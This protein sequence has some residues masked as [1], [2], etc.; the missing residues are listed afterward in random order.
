MSSSSSSSRYTSRGVPA[1]IPP[2]YN[3]T[4]RENIGLGQGDA[5]EGNKPSANAHHLNEKAYEKVGDTRND[6]YDRRY[7]ELNALRENRSSLQAI[8][9]DLEHLPVGM[10][11]TKDLRG[12]SLGELV[13]EIVQRYGFA[14]LRGLYVY[15]VVRDV[16]LLGQR[17]EGNEVI[18]NSFI[19]DTRVTYLP[20]WKV[21]TILPIEY[22]EGKKVFFTGGTLKEHL[23]GMK[24]TFIEKGIAHAHDDR[25]ETE[26]VGSDASSFFFLKEVSLVRRV[27]PPKYIDQRINVIRTGGFSEILSS[28]S[29]FHFSIED[30]VKAYAVEIEKHYGNRLKTTNDRAVR[31]FKE[32]ISLRVFGKNEVSN[33]SVVDPA[34]G[35]SIVLPGAQQCCVDECVSELVWLSKSQ[36]RCFVLGSDGATRSIGLE[37]DLLVEDVRKSMKQENV[38]SRVEAMRRKRSRNGEMRNLRQYEE[39]FGKEFD[40]STKNGYSSSLF[41]SFRKKMRE[42]YRVNPRIYYEREE[43]VE[44]DKDGGMKVTQRRLME[45]ANGLRTPSFIDENPLSFWQG[46][47][48]NLSMFRINI[49]GIIHRHKPKSDQ[50]YQNPGNSKPSDNDKRGYHDFFENENDEGAKSGMLHAIGLFPYVPYSVL[51][52]KHVLNAFFACIEKHTTTAMEKAKL[53]TVWLKNFDKEK[54][55]DL[56]NSQNER[57]EKGYVK[58]LIYNDGGEEGRKKGKTQ[59]ENGGEEEEE[60]FQFEGENKPLVVAYDIET[61]ELTDTAI[62]K[63]LIPEKYLVENPT[64]GPYEQENKQA[65][66]L[67]QWVP[68]NLSDEGMI[69]AKKEK[70]GSEPRIEYPEESW[71]E[72]DEWVQGGDGSKRYKKGWIALDEV[73][74][75]KGGGNLGQCVEDFLE[76][77]YH[78][79]KSHKYTSAHCYAHNGSQ[80]DSI[81]IQAFNTKYKIS[82]V[83]KVRG[84]ILQM[85]ILVPDGVRQTVRD[86]IQQKSFTITFSDTRKFL[87][88]SLASLC[89][90]FKLP[91]CWSKLDF[92]IARINADN[93][94]LPEVMKLVE[95]YGA[96]DAYA[97][98]FIIKQ[99]NR[100]LCLNP[101]EIVQPDREEFTD[102]SKNLQVHRLEEDFCSAFLQDRDLC[103]YIQE[104][105][106]NGGKNEGFTRLLCSLNIFNAQKT[107]KPPITQ[108]CT[109][110]GFVKRVLNEFVTYKTPNGKPLPKA[111][112]MPPLRNIVDMALQ[113][114]RVSSYN[115]VYSSSRFGE[116]IE[117]WSKGDEGKVK[118]LMKEVVDHDDCMITLDMTSEYPTAMRDCPHPMGSLSYC[119]VD[120]C[121]RAVQ[122]IACS[123]CEKQ[124]MLCDKHKLSSSSPQHDLRPFVIILVKELN[125]LPEAKKMGINLFGRK[126]RSKTLIATKGKPL[127]GTSFRKTEGIEYTLETEEEATERLWGKRE[128]TN[129]NEDAEIDWNV[130]G[131][132]QAYTNID[133]YWALKCG[134]K[135]RIVGGLKWE[136]TN[137]L[138]DLYDG[139]FN[140][141]AKAKQEKNNSLQLALKNVLNG[142]YGV[143]CQKVIQTM[144]KVISPPEELFDR[145]VKDNQFAQYLRD[146]HHSSFDSRFILKE[147]IPL[148]TKQSFVTGKMPIEIGEIVGASSPNHI[149]ASVL[150]WARHLMN[151]MMYPCMKEAR[152]GVTYTDTDSLTIPN[153]LYTRL[154]QTHSHLFDATGRSLGTYKND[155]SDYF[156]N[157]RVIFSALGGK[158]VKMHI[159]ACP[160]TGKVKVCNTFK[161]FMTAP[162][163]EE[164][165]RY[166]G[167]KIGFEI[168]SALIE[169]LYDGK[170]NP[171]LGARWTRSL[172]S[173]GVQIE[174]QAFY[175]PTSEAYLNHFSL[176]SA[177]PSTLNTF[178]TPYF[179]NHLPLHV[180]TLPHGAEVHSPPPHLSELFPSWEIEKKESERGVKEYVINGEWK[181]FLDEKIDGRKEEGRRWLNREKLMKFFE[182][183]YYKKDLFYGEETKD[184][185][186]NQ[187][188]QNNRVESEQEKKKREEF[189]LINRIISTAEE[190]NVV[191]ERVAEAMEE[192][193][194]ECL[195]QILNQLSPII[196]AIPSPDDEEQEEED[197]GKGKEKE[198]KEEGEND[199][200]ME[201]EE[202]EEGILPISPS[203]FLNPD[204]Y[205]GEGMG[206]EREEGEMEEFDEE[207]GFFSF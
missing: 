31:K 136:T 12:I 161:G 133:L 63:G 73:K 198:G 66:F 132:V 94:Y 146:N 115:K 18:F 103:E 1:P 54:L 141:R 160:D 78:W 165:F 15:A 87:P 189:L 61:V 27:A 200:D 184:P 8:V 182:L 51:K 176:L 122:A 14:F 148:R 32:N 26:F 16:H 118:E 201:E 93:F 187:E 129:G 92:P 69:K 88:G 110:M 50:L 102:P 34:G 3:D 204:F 83:L 143:H 80:F 5:G 33:A 56:V 43:K 186:P 178:S 22:R 113:G 166:E 157:A 150:C 112:D 125:P 172:G 171:H 77:V 130:F 72:K 19:R 196:E 106:E 124:M 20:L 104:G 127:G 53:D 86:G 74:I 65:P 142:G 179:S 190:N 64:G 164:G 96:N 162:V 144:D 105:E 158:K 114:G 25:L 13:E 76:G 42:M 131:E 68:V 135:F 152:M 67:V 134:F 37:H 35:F 23:D 205:V 59:N 203:F 47:F 111:L 123:D 163:N 147:N 207:D 2:T 9:A 194:E 192:V 70:N 149:G 145:D 24:R 71:S 75:E 121:R 85:K 151:L 183:Y 41:L 199:W 180:H 58:T 167:D 185:R 40:E 191:D 107:M 101:F 120:E 36:I 139:L 82:K 29:M 48:L 155:H 79:A 55:E 126:P 7:H 95:P 140:L 52:D 116:I 173:S 89:K 6:E 156:P 17:N 98:A 195:A 99:I 81:I 39:K 11:L 62:N 174:K 90:D 193:S 177:I 138:C 97:L 45:F 10:K 202:G 154:S 153:S 28:T 84:S 169:I 4:I 188:N 137:V 119:D 46:G 197:K 21:L 206:E 175:A 44:E 108:F 159:I 100:I 168:S 60:R 181:K 117:N 30:L 49:H 38:K 109:M 170:P 57:Y 128:Q 91:S